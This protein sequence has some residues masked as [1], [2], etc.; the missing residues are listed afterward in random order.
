MD[1]FYQLIVCE[2][3]DCTLL[4]CYIIVCKKTNKINN[5]QLI[6]RF[7]FILKQ[8]EN[9]ERIRQCSYINSARKKYL[10]DV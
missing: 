6:E 7:A 1:L 9:S 5:L 4:D 2:T 10:L 3:Y 8:K